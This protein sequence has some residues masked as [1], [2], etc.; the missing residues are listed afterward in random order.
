MEYESGSP[1]VFWV[2]KVV[3]VRKRENIKYG[4]GNNRVLKDQFRLLTP[5]SAKAEG[6]SIVDEPGEG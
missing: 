5:D 4:G 2:E 3:S 6:S 1:L